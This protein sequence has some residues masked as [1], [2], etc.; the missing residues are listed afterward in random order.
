MLIDI[1]HSDISPARVRADAQHELHAGA[2]LPDVVQV[3]REAQVEHL[4]GQGSAVRGMSDAAKT[5]FHR[6]ALA[7][8]PAGMSLE[9]VAGEC[10][11]TPEMRRMFPEM[12]EADLLLIG[13]VDGV[14]E[15][16]FV[17]DEARV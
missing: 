12:P 7:G 16:E 4:R 5:F 15:F 2:V 6:L 17:N 9:D 11:L 14:L 13:T 1:A 10:R 8:L 3:I